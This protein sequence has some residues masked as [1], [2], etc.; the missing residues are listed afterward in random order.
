MKIQKIK[1]KKIKYKGFLAQKERTNSS[2]AITDKCT[3][4]ICPIRSK[5]VTFNNATNNSSHIKQPVQK[6][7]YLKLRLSHQRM[8]IKPDL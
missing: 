6:N 8:F 7:Q 1:L 2:A 5:S 3:V 4:A